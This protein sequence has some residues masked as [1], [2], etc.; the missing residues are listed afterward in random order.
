M[1]PGATAGHTLETTTSLKSELLSQLSVQ[2]QASNVSEDQRNLKF[3]SMPPK[4]SGK[5]ATKV[6]VNE[7][8]RRLAQ[9]MKDKATAKAMPK[10]QKSLGKSGAKQAMASCEN[11]YLCQLLDPEQYGPSPYPDNF[12]DQTTTAL[13]IYNSDVPIDSDSGEFGI[14]VNPTLPDHVRF[15][16]NVAA[17]TARVYNFDLSWT[18]NPISPGATQMVVG[19]G[20]TTLNLGKADGSVYLSTDVSS[21]LELDDG[22]ILLPAYTAGTLKIT[23]GTINGLGV[24]NKATGTIA[25]NCVGSDGSSTAIT[26]TTVT[27]PDNLTKIKLQLSNSAGPLYLL[28][29][30]G[31]AQG[32][33]LQFTT[34]AV[35]TQSWE[36]HSVANYTNLLGSDDVQAVYTA[37]RTVAMTALITYKGDTLYD[38][39]TIAGRYMEGGSTA[40]DQG[41]VS[42]DTLSTARGSYDGASKKGAYA[43]WKP[44]DAVH[45]AFRDVDTDNTSGYYPH[46]VFFGKITTSTISA[47]KLRLRVAM[48]LEAA[49]TTMFVPV[50]FS[51]VAVWEIE[52]ADMAIQTIPRIMEN[53]VHV[54]AIRNFLRG[55]IKKGQEITAS[56]KPYL[57]AMMKLAATAAPLLGL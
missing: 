21:H 4:K 33:T 57:P 52:A 17:S 53:P 24:W 15:L 28:Q 29:F 50:Q 14:E 34:G 45:M 20:L 39:G 47:A 35:V 18:Q 12:G 51:R 16:E 3:A 55:V 22:W 32:F 8:E 13:F 6:V 26:A 41:Y 23:A 30:P 54:E 31:S 11:R 19:T 7:A 9:S 56:V 37:Y 10:V 36:T 5:K 43:W 27:L 38:G 42:Y 44:R 40:S 1:S 49:T 25:C 2:N 46:L 48:V